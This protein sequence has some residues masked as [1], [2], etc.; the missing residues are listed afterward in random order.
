MKAVILAL[1][2]LMAGNLYAASTTGSIGVKLTIYSL[3]KVDGRV[4]VSQRAP[5]IDCGRQISAQPK[6]TES[7]I[8]RNATS[9]QEQRLVTVEW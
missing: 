1:G 7:K 3:C 8:A 5:Q 2:L 6:V 4:S 9:N